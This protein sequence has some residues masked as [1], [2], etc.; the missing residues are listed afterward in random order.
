MADAGTRI[1]KKSV[2]MCERGESELNELTNKRAAL[3]KEKT[4][5]EELIKDLDEQKGKTLINTWQLVNGYLGNIF[6]ALLPNVDARLEPPEGM[7][8]QDGLELRVAFGGKWKDSLSELSG[9]QKS[10]LSL[11][12][13][14]ALL[15]YKPAPFYI[16][17]EVD[18]ALDVSHT[19][20][21]GHMIKTVFPD[22]LNSLKI[23]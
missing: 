18:A 4:T 2:T 20:N 12:L 19:K 21:I 8:A 17:D 22:S 11:S 6:R 16:L 1:N 14:L 9:G 7:T 15:K 13:I 5:I 10:L 23:G 3:E